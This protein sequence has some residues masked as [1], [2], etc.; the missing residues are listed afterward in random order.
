M[1]CQSWCWAWQWFHR[2]VLCRRDY[3]LLVIGIRQYIYRINIVE[4]D[5]IGSEQDSDGSDGWILIFVRVGPFEST[6]GKWTLDEYG[7]MHFPLIPKRYIRAKKR[8][9]MVLEPLIF[10]WQ[11]ISCLILNEGQ[12]IQVIRDQIALLVEAVSWW[13][14]EDDFG[15]N[16]WNDS[17]VVSRFLHQSPTS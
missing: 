17:Q 1:E 6:I 13:V 4:H 14:F 16:C 8:L 10:R 15:Q 5:L 11:S 3:S 9:E 12:K 7:V 2:P